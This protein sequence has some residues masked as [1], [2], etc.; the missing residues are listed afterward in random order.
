MSAADVGGVSG[1]VAGGDLLPLGGCLDVDAERLGQDDDRDVGGQGEQGG[2]AGLPQAVRPSAMKTCTS[3][4][5]MLFVRANVVA[6][7][8]L[9]S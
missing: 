8:A 1:P 3:G 2:A 6:A 7:D 5:S 9:A 4:M